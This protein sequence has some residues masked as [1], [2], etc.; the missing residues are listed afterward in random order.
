VRDVK[1]W[2]DLVD[3]LD[4]LI[5]TVESSLILQSGD[6][7]LADVL[8]CKGRQFQALDRVDESAAIVALESRWSRLEQTILII[9]YFLD[10]KY[11]SLL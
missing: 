6:A 10:P 8:I 2:L 9:A 4:L 7:T 1:F 11:R 3:F 5:P